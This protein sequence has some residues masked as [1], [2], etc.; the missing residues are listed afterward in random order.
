MIVAIEGIDGVGKTTLA[1][2]LAKKVGA[3]YLKFP[4]RS[5]VSGQVIA[6]HLSHGDAC[7]SCEGLPPAAFQALQ[8]AN[9]VEKLTMLRAAS[10]RPEHH[11]ICDRYTASAVVYG[12][13]D[14]LDEAWITSL[15]S[16]L[17]CADLQILLHGDPVQ[18]DRERLRG[19]DREVYENRGIK[20]LEDQCERFMDYFRAHAF[21][22]GSDSWRIFPVGERPRDELLQALAVVVEEHAKTINKAWQNA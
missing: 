15:N 3:F 21:V 1:L 9:R 4:D 22:E 12:G 14:G 6:R 20:G 2:A 10:R 7:R 19:R 11:V 8:L 5:T 18:I 17:P 16:A 13:S